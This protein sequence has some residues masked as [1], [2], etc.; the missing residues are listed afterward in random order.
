[1]PSIPGASTYLRLASDF[2]ALIASTKITNFGDGGPGSGRRPTIDG[3]PDCLA[4]RRRALRCHP[5]GRSGF[6]RV[7]VEIQQRGVHLKFGGEILGVA[8]CV[9]HGARP[10]C[11]PVIKSRKRHHVNRVRLAL[12][13]DSFATLD[14]L[15]VLYAL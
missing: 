2:G 3:Q 10:S 15:L 13:D 11:V 5:D 4:G 14:F 9:Q 12:C 6:C 7:I 1:M 8:H